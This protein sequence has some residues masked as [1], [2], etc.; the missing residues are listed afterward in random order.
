MANTEDFDPSPYV[1]P[2]IMDVPTGIALG[3]AL[4]AAVPKSPPPNIHKASKKLGT[5]LQNLQDAWQQSA[6]AGSAPDKRPADIRVDTAWGGLHAR[7]EAYAQLPQEDF[8]KA[9]RASEILHLLFPDGLGFLTISFN[10]E[11]AEGEKRLKLIEMQNLQSDIQSI[12]GAEF[13]DE[14]QKA[15]LLYGQILGITQPVESKSPINL[16]DPLRALGRAM[17]QYAMQLISLLDE[18]EASL[19]LVRHA[20]HP[21]DQHRAQQSEKRSEKAEPKDP[22]PAEP[23]GPGPE[24]FSDPE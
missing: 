19:A 4:L 9:K 22:L 13:W 8:P 16:V 5:A 7:I 3:T 1:R 2:P 17:V 18:G 10:A 14:L 11:W 12:A 6:S 20:L 24:P 23:P 21:I 15:H